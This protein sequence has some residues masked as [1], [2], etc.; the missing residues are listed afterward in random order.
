MTLVV[1]E[2]S[3]YGIVMVEHTFPPTQGVT[4]GATRRELDRLIAV[5]TVPHLPA[6]IVAWGTGMLPTGAGYKPVADWLVEFAA[7]HTHVEPVG[8]YAEALADALQ[9]DAAALEEPL[10]FHIAGYVRVDGEP[11]PTLYHVRNNEAVLGAYYLHKFQPIQEFPPKH[12][13]RGVF[14]IRSCDCE[15]HGNL[16][17]RLE[18]LLPDIERD[19]EMSLAMPHPSLEGRMAFLGACVNFASDLYASA[20]PQGTQMAHIT[21]LGIAPNGRFSYQSQGR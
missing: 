7:R 17:E 16:F 5:Q 15:R 2:L 12:P 1:T 6:G 21:T 4:A 10:G 13:G 14:R 19:G 18:T 20:A 8:A 11:L 9:E 3:A